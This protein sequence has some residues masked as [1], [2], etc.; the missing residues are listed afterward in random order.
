METVQQSILDL[1]VLKT[2]SGVVLI[3]MKQPF[4]RS[5]SKFRGSTSENGELLSL[6]CLNK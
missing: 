3:L 5:S 4:K 1:P 6:S 2:L